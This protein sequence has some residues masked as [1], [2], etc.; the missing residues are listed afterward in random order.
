MVVPIIRNGTVIGVLDVDSSELNE[1]D[2]T[3]QQFLEEIV[4]A[5]QF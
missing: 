1:F 2:T 4:D 5:I 3:D